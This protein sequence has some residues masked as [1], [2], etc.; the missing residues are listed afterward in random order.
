VS[1]GFNELL[2]RDRLSY[3]ATAGGWHIVPMIDLSYQ[4]IAERYGYSIFQQSNTATQGMLKEEDKGSLFYITPAVDLTLARALDI[5]AGVL[6]NASSRI[7]TGNRRFFPFL[8]AA[9]D[10]LH[11]N[12]A[13]AGRNSWKLF[14]SYARRPMLYIDGYSSP[15]LTSAGADQSLFAVLHGREQVNYFGTGGAPVEFGSVEPGYWTWQAGT[16]FRT[17][18]GRVTLQYSFERRNYSFVMVRI[19]DGKEGYE[20]WTASFHHVDLRFKLLDSKAASW[21][22]GLAL[23]LVK[24]KGDKNG[25]YQNIG[26]ND[27]PIGDVYPNGYSWMGGW[28]NRL[29]FGRFSAGL[30]VLYHLG[31]V[32]HPGMSK[33]TAVAPNIYAGYR[34]GL[35]HERGLELFVESRELVMNRPTDLADGRRYYTLGASLAL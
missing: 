23:S 27:T 14:G 20:P 21:L 29:Q 15:D 5:E 8:T 4:H 24:S 31:A 13:D 12:A 7:D 2:L 16:A 3:E 30:D 1:D 17:G 34:F 22:T 35:P 25:F 18:D 19:S 6:A 32:A 9:V 33:N 28:V 26:L 11:L 10:L